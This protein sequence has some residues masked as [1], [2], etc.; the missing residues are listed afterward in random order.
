MLNRYVRGQ[1]WAIR[2]E[3]V[4]GDRVFNGEHMA[5]ILGVNKERTITVIPSTSKLNVETKILTNVELELT[6]LDGVKTVGHF[7]PNMIQTIDTKKAYRYVGM[8][9]EDS[10]IK[11]QE[12]VGRYLGFD[13]IQYPPVKVVLESPED[14]RKWMR[15]MKDEDPKKLNER[16]NELLGVSQAIT[17]R[18]TNTPKT[19]NVGDTGTCGGKV[20]T[21]E[22]DG[23]EMY[24]RPIDNWPK[25]VLNDIAAMYKAGDPILGIAYKYGVSDSSIGRWVHRNNIKHGGNK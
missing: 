25:K 8:L 11:V 23:L 18:A 5:L 9:D 1:V 14:P 10:V 22:V 2:T 21:K 20:F 4:D 17:N 6:N 13:K 7:I 3:I 15:E 12:A 16:L 24:G 19:A